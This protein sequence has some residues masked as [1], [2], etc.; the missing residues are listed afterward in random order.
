MSSTE[1]ESRVGGYRLAVYTEKEEQANV[2]TSGLGVVLSLLGLFVLLSRPELQVDPWRLVSCTLYGFILVFFYTVSTL[3]HAVR[4]PRL[5]YLFRILD[6]TCIFLVI[7]GTYT[8]FALVSMRFSGG[9]PLFLAVWGLAIAGMVFKAIMTGRMRI[10]GPILYLLLGWLVVV[11]WD[12]LRASVPDAGIAWLL[13]GGFFYSFGLVFFAWN[14]L[15]FNHLIWHLFVIAG[16]AS[17]FLAILWY[18]VPAEA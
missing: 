1:N 13:A 10:L 4:Q 11:A 7:A 14:R 8:P 12:P 18:V 2:V 6:H 15:P 5:K 3:Y 17:H 16:S 9:W